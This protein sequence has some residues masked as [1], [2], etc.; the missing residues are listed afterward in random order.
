[1]T[2]V[3]LSFRRPRPAP[4]QASVTCVFCPWGAAQTGTNAIEISALLRDLLLRHLAERHPEQI[5]D[6]A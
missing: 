5:K 6:P 3:V 2:P 1:M 4:I